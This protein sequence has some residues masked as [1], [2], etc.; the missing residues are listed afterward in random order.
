MDRGRL[1]TSYMGLVAGGDGVH[2]GHHIRGPAP[3]GHRILPLLDGGDV[4]RILLVGDTSPDGEGTVFHLAG[5]VI[6]KSCLNI[7]LLLALLIVSDIMG[8]R[9]V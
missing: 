6:L 7:I 5:E 9:R 3:L 1:G 4:E 8:H 2:D